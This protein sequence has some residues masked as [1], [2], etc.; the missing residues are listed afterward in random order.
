MTRKKKLL[1]TIT[2]RI[3]AT[4]TTLI[5][6]YLLSGEFKVATSVA[7]FEVITKMVIYYLHETIWDRLNVDENREEGS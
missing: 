1:K 2:W 6:V 3:T 5:I 4:T 7:L